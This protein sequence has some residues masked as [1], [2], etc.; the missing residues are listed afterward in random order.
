MRRSEKFNN[1]CGKVKTKCI[2]GK[3]LKNEFH[4]IFDI[5]PLNILSE[6]FL[7]SLKIQEIMQI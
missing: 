1:R 7:R 3:A 5:C 4:S 6:T 2:T